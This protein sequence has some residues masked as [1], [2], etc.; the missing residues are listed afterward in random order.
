M[1]SINQ[2][3]IK[4]IRKKSSL[5]TFSSVPIGADGLLID[6]LSG[7]D[8]QQELKLGN[9]HYVEIKDQTR[10]PDEGD[11]YDVTIIK[12]WYLDEAKPSTVSIDNLTS[13]ILYS[14][15]IQITDDKI[16]QILYKGAIDSSNQLHTKVIDISPSS[17]AINQQIDETVNIQIEE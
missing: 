14:L 4:E 1:S 11:P 8:L 10:T 17:T 5:N 16:E 7:L 13:H 12:Q 2:P 15:Y 9:S 3:R 6:M